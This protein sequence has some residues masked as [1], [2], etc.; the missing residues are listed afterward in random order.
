MRIVEAGV[1]YFALVF[2]AGFMLG[3]I[4]TLWV[5][6]SLGS[7]TAELLEASHVRGHNRG[8]ALDCAPISDASPVFQ[9]R[10]HGLHCA[11][12]HAAGGIY[13]GPL[14]P[15]LLHPP[16]SRQ[17]RSRGGD[18]L[19]HDAC[20]IRCYATPGSTNIRSNGKRS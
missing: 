16:I 4:R 15:R 8:R 9:P 14:A 11:G 19:L 5:V 3:A 2:E 10:W 17:P 13:A 18:R 6:P 7:R 20:A 12:A 1:L